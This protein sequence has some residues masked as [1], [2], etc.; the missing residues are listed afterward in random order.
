MKQIK[1]LLAALVFASA[2]MTG[3]SAATI[4]WG[5]ATTI[6]NN[7]SDVSTTGTTFA[8]YLG[9]DS[10]DTV[11]L[12]G[13]VFTG[14]IPGMTRTDSS[15]R[16]SQGTTGDYADLLMDSASPPGGS[17]TINLTGLAI[18]QAYEVQIWSTDQN[19]IGTPNKVTT[20]N[21]GGG[22][23]EL[24]QE[25]FAG[26]PGQFAIGTFTADA[27]TQDLAISSTRG[28]PQISALQ[29]RVVP[30]PWSLALLGLGGLLIGVRRRR[31]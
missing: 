21:G 1:T 29:V 28:W 4:T 6:T 26:G 11:T 16:F 19:G 13:V 17:G 5:S 30:E 25:A 18:G 10:V 2:A 9:I 23:V 7:A 12:N 20:V 24:Q 14:Q 15:T 22:T 27:T 31:G 3:A 8:G